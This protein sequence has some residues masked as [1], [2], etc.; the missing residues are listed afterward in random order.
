MKNESVW[1][2][3]KKSINSLFFLPCWWMQKFIKRNP[4]LW[5]FGAWF[6]SRYADN[7]RA[8]FE[9]VVDNHPEIKAYWVTKNNKVYEDLKKKSLPVVYADSKEGKNIQKHASIFFLTVGLSDVNSAYLNGCRI[10]WLWHGMPLK[11]V[12]EPGRQFLTE[13]TFWK[14]IKT[15]IRKIILPYEFLTPYDGY[16]AQ[17]LSTSPFFSQYLQS[18]F[19]IK[20]ENM[21]ELGQPRNDKL[22][23]PTI[24]PLILDLRNKFNNPQIVLYMPTFRDGESKKNLYFNPFATAGFDLATFTKALSDNNIVF[25]YKGH[26]FDSDNSLLSQDNRIITISDNDYDDL[27]TFI[28]DVDVL[29]TDYSSVY[30]DFLLCRKP[31]ILFPFDKDSYISQSRPFYYDYELLQAKRVYSWQELTAALEEKDYYVPSEDTIKL[32]NTYIDGDSCKR[33][34]EKIMQAYIK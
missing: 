27:Y 25:V 21:L 24:E 12:G 6:G 16:P 32:F 22:F 4:T 30:F 13:H 9:Y 11:I 23:S 7:S 3:I 1:E 28:K 29:I 10:V 20:P 5:V 8:F 17:M 26:F 2:I 18:S 19:K 31:I 33:L 14:K 34:F 15:K